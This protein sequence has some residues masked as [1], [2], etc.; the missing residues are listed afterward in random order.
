[1]D[2]IANPDNR[3]VAAALAMASLVVF[4]LLIPAVRTLPAP[5]RDPDER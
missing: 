1:M 5:P 2:A 4:F 3:T